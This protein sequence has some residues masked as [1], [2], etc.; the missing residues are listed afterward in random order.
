MPCFA[1]KRLPSSLG[2]RLPAAAPPPQKR[3]KMSHPSEASLSDVPCSSSDPRSMATMAMS[4][5][6]LANAD[7]P[8]HVPRPLTNCHAANEVCEPRE[9]E[10]RLLFQNIGL[11]NP[12][13]HQAPERMPQTLLSWTASH[14]L[15]RDNAAQRAVKSAVV[16][17]PSTAHA[18]P[19]DGSYISPP[20]A[21]VYSAFSSSLSL[22]LCSFDSS[23]SPMAYKFSA[24][25]G[26]STFSSKQSSPASTMSSSDAEN[27]NYL[28]DGLDDY[29][30][31]LPRDGS[32]HYAFS[33]DACLSETHG[34][35]PVRASLNER[36]PI[37]RSMSRSSF[38]SSSCMDS[39]PPWDYP[40][41]PSDSSVTTPA[42]SEANFGWLPGLCD[43]L[44]GQEVPFGL[45]AKEKLPEHGYVQD[46]PGSAPLSP[47]CFLTYSFDA[48]LT[49]VDVPPAS[50]SMLS[51]GTGARRHSEPAKLSAFQFPPFFLEQFS[52][53]PPAP[54]PVGAA[55]PPIADDISSSSAG[56][57]SS[58]APH[59]TE[60]PRPL[61]IKQ[62]KPVRGYK[63]PIL[64]VDL[65]YDPK[66]FVRRHSEPVLP[67]RELDVFSHL[68]LDVSEESA[69]EDDMMSE[70]ADEESYGDE[71]SYE[72][73]GDEEGMDDMSCEDGY[74]M[75][76][77]AEDSHG[78]P[79][80]DPQWS[81][82]QP[83]C[84]SSAQSQAWP[85]ADFLAADFDW[86]TA[87]A[88]PPPQGTSTTPHMVG[89][90]H[91]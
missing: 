58:I 51:T 59:Q 6:L 13:T 50:S 57:P 66:D 33:P 36:S 41:P 35:D 7:Q 83:A 56:A 46:L 21:M 65:Q 80:F 52:Q 62:P 10:H 1:L 39:S 32:S 43:P 5:T 55:P 3:I 64:C 47:S 34:C 38:G 45:E 91:Q 2:A 31:G 14:Q 26:P 68:P 11:I 76:G 61:E 28:Y 78:E 90:Q 86:T 71:E 60:L 85:C 79:L 18:T 40:T 69:E 22:P 16:Y 77:F 24:E 44:F 27:L 63:P 54:Q 42:P 82:F 84:D 17:D 29:L 74:A 12:D 73:M 30:G 67:L 70:G 37:F 9:R 15:L 53:I 8:H 25:P 72:D 81:W 20:E 87:F 75:E 4:A 88:C 19:E 49:D 48:F 89:F 23:V